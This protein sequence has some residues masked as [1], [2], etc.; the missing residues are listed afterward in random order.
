MANIGIDI[1]KKGKAGAE[2]CKPGAWTKLHWTGKLIDGSVITDS[3]QE[4]DGLPKV[5]NLGSSSEYKCWDLALT[6]LTPGTKAK[7]HCPSYLV[8]GTSEAKTPLGDT[9]VPKG[10][11]V[12]FDV[13]VVD[14]NI[15]PETADTLKYK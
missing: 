2:K 5:F 4:H 12:N 15:P 7:I 10:S 3:R 14:C 8:Y 11:D 1:V 6:Q 13:E 9:W